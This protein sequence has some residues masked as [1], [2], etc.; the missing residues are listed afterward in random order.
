MVNWR[1]LNRLHNK[2]RH[3]LDHIGYLAYLLQRLT[4]RPTIAL[5]TFDLTYYTSIIKLIVINHSC[6]FTARVSVAYRGL[7]TLPNVFI[8]Q[9]H[10]AQAETVH[11]D[12]GVPKLFRSTSDWLDIPLNSILTNVCLTCQSHFCDCHIQSP[13]FSLNECGKK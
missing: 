2:L 11:F 5:S 13:K 12:R 7:L 4:C 3:N 8:N 9:T 1:V 6:Y 10:H